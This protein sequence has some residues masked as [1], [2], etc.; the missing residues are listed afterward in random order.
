MNDC[1]EFTIRSDAGEGSSWSRY[2]SDPVFA[3]LYTVGRRIELDYVVQ[4]H[5]P[6]SFDGGAEHKIP[7]EIHVDENA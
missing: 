1:P 3:A 6:K 4:R 7:I 2:A 5:R